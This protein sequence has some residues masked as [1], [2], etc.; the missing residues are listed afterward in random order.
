[1]IITLGSGRGGL[2][3]YLE[4][5]QKQGRDLHRDELDERIILDGDLA[6]FETV[7]STHSGEGVAYD[8]ITLSWSENYV[9]NEMLHLAVEKWK[10]HAL[11]AWP[12][13]DRDRIPFYAEAHRPRILSY[14]NHLTGEEESRCTHIHIALGRHDL[15]TGESISVL[16]YLGGKTDNTKFVDAFQESF[17][18]ANGFSSPKDNPKVTSETAIDIL[19]RYT[20]YVPDTLGTVSQQKNALEIALQKDILAQNITSWSDF[21]TLLKKYGEVSTLRKGRFNECFRVKSAGNKKSMRLTGI[22]YQRQ[23]IERPTHEKEFILIRKAKDA[24]LEQMQPRKQPEYIAGVLDEWYLFR[25]RE[26]RYLHTG[27]KFYKEVYQPADPQT[28]LQILDDLERKNRR[29]PGVVSLPDF[30]HLTQTQI[31]KGV[32]YVLRQSF[33]EGIP[34]DHIIRAEQHRRI[35][36]ANRASRVHELS[37]GSLDAGRPLA[38]SIL[39]DSLP[40]GL[41]NESPRE[42]QDVRRTGASAFGSRREVQ[43]GS[44]KYEGRTL[45]PSS[46]IQQFECELWEAYEKA[47]AKDRF[48]EIRKRIDCHQLLKKLSHDQKINPALYQVTVAKDGTPRIQCGSRSLTPNDFLSKE[49]GLP[50]S[51]AAP[52]LK[53]VYENQINQRTRSTSSPLW[54]EF[55]AQFKEQSSS[56]FA[57][58]KPFNLETRELNKSITVRLKAQ[59]QAAL[60][61]LSGARKQDEI[62]RQASL[63]AQERAVFDSERE[64]LFEQLRPLPKDQAW[65]MF[66]RDRAQQGDET[67]LSELR[68]IDDSARVVPQTSITGTIELVD[69]EDEKKRRKRIRE[70]ASTIF[71]QFNVNLSGD[72]TYHQNGQAVLRD[73]GNHLA[74][75]DENNEEVLAAALMLAKERFGMN[76]TLTGSPE[77]QARLVKIAVAQN[78]NVRFVDPN[79]ESLR[80][81]EIARKR[82]APHVQ[83]VPAPALPEANSAPTPVAEIEANREA[84]VEAITVESW[85][86]AQSKPL[87]TT[88]SE[89]SSTQYKVVYVD[90][91]VV[92]VDYGKTLGKHPAPNFDVQIDDMVIIDKTSNLTLA[93]EKGKGLDI[94]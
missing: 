75:L 45:Q 31:N 26:N 30:S 10:E 89:N 49:L 60:V 5:G 72:V 62:K 33:D 58:R 13:A 38:G 93:P 12:E 71:K 36:E 78:I 81:A 22:F 65:R 48:A 32:D 29:T 87:S 50:W 69:D 94:E 3:D 83:P 66:L 43:R 20:G 9:S 56:L 55:S 80:L 17:N 2:K 77:F 74:V 16:G 27:S 11:A 82:P 15:L 28:K 52:I 85:L 46:L 34:P 63:A 51:K 86:A 37:D 1:M 7:T 21:E 57:K 68:K 25:A 64:A 19:A 79:L 70:S 18:T 42:N 92:I 76:L 39:P 54:K 47:S 59:K 73:E 91:G 67:A 4:N 40:S 84:K 14:K 53:A 88:R 90:L 35:V 23:F 6:V 41:G 61:G 8:H 44:V 24:Y